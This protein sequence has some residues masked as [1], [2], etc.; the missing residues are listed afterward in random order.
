MTEQ[1][2]IIK[3]FV[4]SPG[5][6][7]DE[8]KSLPSIIDR[9]NR[10]IAPEKHI[11]LELVKW[12]TH[13]WPGFGQDPQDVINEQIG[14]YDIFLGIMWNRLGTPTNRAQ[15]GTVEEFFIAYNKWKK[16]KKPKLLF[17][18]NKKPSLLNTNEE[19]EQ[20]RKVINFRDD[21]VKPEGLYWEYDGPEV[22]KDYVFDHLM[23]E[24]QIFTFCEKKRTTNDV[25]TN[26]V[27]SLYKDI[28]PD[29]IDLLRVPNSRSIYSSFQPSAETPFLRIYSDT[30]FG[31]IEVQSVPEG[32][33]IPEPVDNKIYLIRDPIRPYLIQIGETRAERKKGNPEAIP[34]LTNLSLN[35]VKLMF[36]FI[37]ND[38]F[39]W[40][41]MVLSELATNPDVLGFIGTNDSDPEV[42]KIAANNPSAP[43][44]LQKKECRFCNPA[45]RELR[46][47][48]WPTFS[49]KTIIFRN[50]YPYGPF[51][52]YIA[53]PSDPI[54]SWEDIGEQHL[55]DMNCQIWSFLHWKKEQGD[56][57]S[58]GVYIGFNS[59]IRHL[60]LGKRIRASAGASI[61][62]VHKQIWGMTPG[63]ANIGDY[64]ARIC[65]KFY[66]TQKPIDYL[67][68]YLL[69]LRQA[70]HVIWEDDY[71]AL[72][73]PI[74]QIS[75]HELQIIVKNE[76]HNFLELDIHEIKSLSKAEYYVTQFYK[77]IEITSFNEILISEPFNKKTKGFRLIMAF[78]TREVDLAVSE[79]NNLFVV[80]KFPSDTLTQMYRFKE[81]I[82]KKE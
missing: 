32:K 71:V 66:S 70:G 53:M 72:F 36:P 57:N 1:M 28:T 19:L 40:L 26:H 23:R 69:C 3:V 24:I 61:A 18:F 34:D 77:M 47:I 68:S 55:E 5:D 64:L 67:G 80:D 8:R 49:E 65:S 17:Y 58:A 22:F 59:T 30:T 46:R 33:P 76:K 78:I 37:Q 20:R 2:K 62:H 79:L 74:G 52:H 4:A 35:E 12:E 29:Q 7:E 13:A 60:V 14:D 21:L 81:M 48:H 75:I 56:L 31:F 44:D 41:R 27:C 50:D 25:S 63:S 16:I 38:S 15:S 11:V 9:L 6:C 10:G 54:H 45:F 43:K 39:R 82:I 51:F 73:V 42:K